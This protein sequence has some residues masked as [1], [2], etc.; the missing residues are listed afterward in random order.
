M[1]RK[2]QYTLIAFVLIIMVFSAVVYYQGFGR[3]TI[4]KTISERAKEYLK[5]KEHSVSL[6]GANLAGLNSQTATEN[7]GR[8]EKMNSCFNFTIPFPVNN[9]TH[10]GECNEYF[11]V[12]NPRGTIYANES[13]A[14][15]SSLDDLSDVVMRRMKTDTYEESR[16]QAG[17]RE[18]L[19]FRNKEEIFQK[20]AFYYINGKVFALTLT[21]DDTPEIEK[22]FA[23]ILASVEFL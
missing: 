19:V 4:N 6:Q 22:K 2:F 20:T 15:A 5:D 18:F 10:Q 12:I 14:S 16:L 23:A 1:K 11:S 21:S 13:A 3:R 8:H 17:D 9:Y 7:Y